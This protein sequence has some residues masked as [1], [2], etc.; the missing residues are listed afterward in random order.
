MRQLKFR[1]WTRFNTIYRMD[2]LSGFFLYGEEEGQIHLFMPNNGGDF[3]V[4]QKNVVLMQFTGLVDSDGRDIY[5]GDIIS[6]DDKTTYKVF[7]DDQNCYW[8]ILSRQGDE[9][10]PY[11]GALIQNTG[12]SKS[13]R[14][15]IIGNIYQNPELLTEETLE[16]EE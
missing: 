7:W 10:G 12:F 2:Y 15:I 4:P 13:R 3:V 16:V 1:A 14:R 11:G 8:A 9:N 6:I 5:E